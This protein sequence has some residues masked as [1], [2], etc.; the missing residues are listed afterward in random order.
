MTIAENKI[1]NVISY[2]FLSNYVV[3]DKA[4]G[5]DFDATIAKFAGR[6]TEFEALDSMETDKIAEAVNSVFDKY[7]NIPLNMDTISGFATMAMNP[8]PDM[9]NIL[10]DRIKKYIRDNADASEK[11]DKET[12]EI[13]QFAEPDRTR[14][15][16]IKKGRGQGG[17]R[18]WS[19]VPMVNKPA[20]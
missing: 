19:D 9:H 13:I 1:E 16:S 18:R 6:L 2:N 20:E 14:A 7:P 8:S 11:K 4:G 5:M 12:G 10:K 17:V 3:R 15:F